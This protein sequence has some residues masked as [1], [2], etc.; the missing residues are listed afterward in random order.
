MLFVIVISGCSSGWDGEGE[1]VT[2]YMDFIDCEADGAR[3]IYYIDYDICNSFCCS[4]GGSLFE[5]R[6]KCNTGCQVDCFGEIKKNEDAGSC[7]K[8]M[9]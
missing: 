6:D 2:N 8:A 3:D 4:P 1:A 9:G 5:G 7:V